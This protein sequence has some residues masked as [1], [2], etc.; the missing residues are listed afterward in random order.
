MTT[1]PTAWLSNLRA[2]L[3]TDGTQ[4]DPVVAGLANGNILVSWQDINDTAGPG[5]GSDVVGTILDA[6]GDVVRAPF[7]LNAFATGR[8]ERD[9]VLAADANGGFVVVY[10]HAEGIESNI[11]WDRYDAAG[12]RTNGGFVVQDT[13]ETVGYTDPSVAFR[14]DGSFVVTYDRIVGQDQSIRA[15]PVS[16]AGVAG[17]EIILRADDLPGSSGSNPR[18]P[19]SATLTNGVVVTAY[20]E[21]EDEPDIEIR[22]L[23][24]NGTPG[25]N[26]NVNVDAVLDSDPRIAALSG[27][28]FVVTWTA[29]SDLVGRVYNADG[30]AAGAQFAVA[31]GPDSQDEAD[32]IGLEDG[33]FFVVWDNDTKAQLEGRRFDASGAPVGAIVVVDTDDRTPG[34]AISMSDLSLTSDGRILVTW[35]NGEIFTAILDPRESRITVQPGDGVTTARQDGSVVI[36]TGAADVLFGGAGNDRLFGGGGADLVEGG[37]GNDIIEGGLTFDDTLRGGDGNDTIQAVGGGRIEGNGGNDTFF[38]VNASTLGG[39]A[40]ADSDIFD[41]GAGIDVFNAANETSTFYTINLAN[42]SVNRGAYDPQN[43]TLANFENAVGSQGND[44][45]VGDVKANFLRGAGGNDRLVGFGGNDTLIGDGGNDFVAGGIGNDLLGGADGA[46]SIL[47]GQGADRIFGAAGNDT[48]AGE[49]GDDTIAGGSGN[50]LATGGDGN[51]QLFGNEGDDL[52]GGGLGNDILSGGLGNDRL[53]G[54]AGLDSLAGDAGNDSLTGGD[55]NDRLAG[56]DGRDTV[57]GDAGADIVLG[58]GGND[59]LGGGGGNDLLGG[60][61]GDDAVYGGGGQDRLFGAAG[62]D[63]LFGGDGI[64]RLTGGDGADVLNGGAGADVFVFN[65]VRESAPAGRDAIL[66]FVTGTDRVDLSVID[67]NVSLAGNQDFAF[68]GSAAFDGAGQLRF[69]TNGTDG[70]LVGEVDGAG[71]ADMTILLRGVTS[72]SAGDLLL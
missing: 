66:D 5:A 61:A 68:I 24:A 71:A 51:D 18:N 56:G 8:N 14:A 43:V 38:V 17:A 16:A 45:I 27:G 69:V 34:S 37:A 36:G 1:T 33:G 54:S 46:D 25:F 59:L 21:N 30:T 11:L 12:Q 41:G 22:G 64:D 53:F 52:M 65:L 4:I 40:T 32:V 19:D 20:V 26:A 48:L 23:N 57:V 55:G 6:R 58:E 15:V 50:D 62:A 35:R 28:G 39:R 63:R 9:P 7:Q 31:A 29:A 2:N 44:R 60:G 47:G 49:A 42:R 3:L 67:A 70:F 13:S 10:V 72:M